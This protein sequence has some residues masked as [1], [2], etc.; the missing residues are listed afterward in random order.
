VENCP[1]N[2]LKLGQKIC[3]GNAPSVIKRKDLPHNT[4]WGPDKWNL[5]YRT[6]K[7]VVLD[8]GSSPCTG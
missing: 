2:A 5:E 8:S 6:N 7:Q 4:A 3:S 1:T